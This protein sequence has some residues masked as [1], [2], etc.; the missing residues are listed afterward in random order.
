MDDTGAPY[1]VM[2]LLS[3]ETLAALRKRSGGRLA[4]DIVLDI[5]HQLLDVLSAAHARGVIHR[6][7]KPENLFWESGGRLQVLD[8]GVARSFEHIPGSTVDTQAS[9]LGRRFETRWLNNWTAD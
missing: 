7:I 5:T 3:G 6:D 9:V 1:L 8:F 4:L 2:E